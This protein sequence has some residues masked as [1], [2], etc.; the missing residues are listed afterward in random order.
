MSPFVPSL[1]RLGSWKGKRREGGGGDGQHAMGKSRHF[2][3][4]QLRSSRPYLLATL[5]GLVSVSARQE[6][7]EI[8]LYPASVSSIRSLNLET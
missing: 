1:D 7:G 6:D 8:S 4:I 3:S 5:P 2:V